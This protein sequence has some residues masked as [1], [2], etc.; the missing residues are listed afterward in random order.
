MNVSLE[1]NNPLINQ[2]RMILPKNQIDFQHASNGLI[3]Q[4]SDFEKV[5]SKDEM[6]IV[7]FEGRL[8]SKN[9]PASVFTLIT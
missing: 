7:Y 2:K 8:R 3:R 1:K 5:L 6:L 4:D 9:S